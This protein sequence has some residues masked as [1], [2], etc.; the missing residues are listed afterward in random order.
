MW[1]ARNT[2][3]F[4]NKDTPAIEVVESAIYESSPDY[5]HNITIDRLAP[6]ATIPQVVCK[7][8]C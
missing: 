8:I 4:K 1:Y 2:K 3:V 7:N 6:S 5:Q